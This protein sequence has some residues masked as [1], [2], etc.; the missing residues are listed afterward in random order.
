MIDIILL[1]IK[2]DCASYRTKR[3]KVVLTNCLVDDDNWNE[4]EQSF[5]L[6]I[7]RVVYKRRILFVVFYSVLHYTVLMCISPDYGLFVILTYSQHC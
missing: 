2:P 6:I 7:E 5:P 1:Q 3:R 4:E